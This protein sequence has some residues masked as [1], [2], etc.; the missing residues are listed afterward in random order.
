[1]A[2][3]YGSHDTEDIPAAQDSP[4]LDPVPPEHPMQEGDNELSDKYCE[5]TNN[6]HPLAELLEQFCQCKDQF[7]RLKSNVP[8][9]HPQ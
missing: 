1:M 9:P 4:P 7:E 3:R 5:E 6:Y 2:T 8:N